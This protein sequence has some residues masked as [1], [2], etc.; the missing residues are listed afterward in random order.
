MRILYVIFI[1]NGK[2]ETHRMSFINRPYIFSFCICGFSREKIHRIILI[3][4][5]YVYTHMVVLPVNRN[6]DSLFCL[7]SI[8]K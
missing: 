6:A 4:V 1:H 7:F 2:I 3:Y 5:M 8:N